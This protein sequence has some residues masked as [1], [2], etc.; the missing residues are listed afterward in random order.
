L[1]NEFIAL[2]KETAVVGYVGAID[3]TKA[4]QDQGSNTYEFMMPYLVMAVVYIIIVA[5]IAGLVKLMER[6]LA[7]SERHS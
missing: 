7:R 3:I 1:G 4:F 5:A 2:V 6:R